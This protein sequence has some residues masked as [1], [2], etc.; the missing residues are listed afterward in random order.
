M[1]MMKCKSAKGGVTLRNAISYGA[2]FV[3]PL[4]TKMMENPKKVCIEHLDQLI[5]AG[6]D[7]WTRL[8]RRKRPIYEIYLSGLGTMRSSLVMLCL[9]HPTL[10]W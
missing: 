5:A 9:Q 7:I 3:F 6:L 2:S 4:F 10:L 1:N 8:D